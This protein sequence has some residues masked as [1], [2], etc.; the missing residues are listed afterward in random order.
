LYWQGFYL[1]AFQIYA[2]F[3]GYTDI[4]RASATLFGFTLPENFNRPYFA[5]TVGDFWNRWHLS[6]TAWFREYIF[7]P[8]SRSLLIR[9]D[10]R[11]TKAAQIA[12]NSITMILIGLW[13]GAAWTFVGWGLWNGLLVSIERV[14][15]IKPMTQWQKVLGGIIT[16]HLIALGWVLF[17]AES[18]TSAAHFIAGMVSFTQV[19]WISYF[20]PPV[21]LAAAL[22]FGLDLL[23]DRAITT[24]RPMWHLG[25]MTASVFII[26]S[27]WLIT[28]AHGSDI[29]PFIYGRF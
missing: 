29:R 21:I 27:L 9:L 23:R 10:K 26:A 14:F 8:L 22:T 3:S 13:H 28:L 4:A 24:P 20:A 25:L 5:S 15:N 2:D 6:L 7:F 18:F 16:F 1:Y 11:Y 17:R 12:S 19:Y